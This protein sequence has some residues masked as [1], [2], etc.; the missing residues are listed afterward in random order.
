MNKSVV[1]ATKVKTKLDPSKKLN[2]I[3]GPVGVS[4]RCAPMRHECRNAISG[5]QLVSRI[6]N[7]PLNVYHVETH[8]TDML[9][10]PYIKTLYTHKR[11]CFKVQC[12]KRSNG[13]GRSILNAVYSNGQYFL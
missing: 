4:V 11:H 5:Y 8:L 10:S 9:S 7:S 13:I 1:L 12:L 6:P 2:Q 3:T